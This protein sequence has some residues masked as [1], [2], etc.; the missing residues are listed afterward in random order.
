MPTSSAETSAVSRSSPGTRCG[1]VAQTNILAS[2]ISVLAKTRSGRFV[3]ASARSGQL[4]IPNEIADVEE[5]TK[6]AYAM[7]RFGGPGCAHRKR[8]SVGQHRRP[9]RR[10]Q[11]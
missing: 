2:I 11:K 1:I 5:K 10:N 3:R 6:A 8:G 4:L 9:L 7:L